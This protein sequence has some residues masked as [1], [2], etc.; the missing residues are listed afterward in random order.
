MSPALPDRIPDH[1]LEALPGS[2]AREPDDAGF[3]EDEAG[4]RVHYEVFGDSE[5]VSPMT[6]S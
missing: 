2:R 3:V 4:V 1:V 6:S 5:D